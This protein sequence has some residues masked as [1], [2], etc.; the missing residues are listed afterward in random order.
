MI[1][2]TRAEISFILLSELAFLTVAALP[3]G[4]AIGWGLM[5]SIAGF[6]DTEVYRMPVVFSWPPVAWACL[7][8]IVASTC[9]GLVVRQRLDR[10]DL[11]EVLKI[12]Q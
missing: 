10:L 6:A 7:T 5:Q 2:F 9:S 1:G 11:V 12:S 8:V 3:V 4:T